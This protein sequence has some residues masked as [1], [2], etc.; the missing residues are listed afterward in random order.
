MSNT[1]I[2]IADDKQIE[3]IAKL[4]NEDLRRELNEARECLREAIAA[5]NSICKPDG[6]PWYEAREQ[7]L[8][9]WSKAAGLEE[10]K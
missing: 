2:L 9:R 8:E 4:I 10:T 5:V 6:W 1:K 7:M 3:D